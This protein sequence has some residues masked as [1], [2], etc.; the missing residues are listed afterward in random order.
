LERPGTVTI[1]GVG[2]IGGSIGLAIRARNAAYRV[3][4]VDLDPGRLERASRLG[5]IDCAVPSLEAGVADAEIVV[6]SAPVTASVAL[7]LEAARRGPESMLITDVGSTKARI[8][9][10]SEADSQARSRFVGGH[11]IAGSERQGVEYSRADLFQGRVCA[12]TPTPRTPLDRVERTRVFWT[13]LGAKVVEV[14]PAIH[15]DQLAFTSHLPHAVASALASTIPTEL[16]AM[17]AGAYR[18]GTRVADAE[19]SLWAGIFL[20]NRRPLLDALSAFEGEIKAFRQA[21]EAGDADRLVSWWNRGRARRSSY[22]EP[23]IG[24]GKPG[25]I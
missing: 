22:V 13:A 4:G 5:A 21:L 18:D 20:D 2:L 8:V 15:D 3:I 25:K 23:E 6:V 7:I 1:I 17:A 14:D 11:P 12:L 24:R 10:E 16:F 19:G 9:A